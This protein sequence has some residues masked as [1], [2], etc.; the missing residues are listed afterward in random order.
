MWNHYSAAFGFVWCLYCS[1]MPGTLGGECS[2]A[3]W[4]YWAGR[5]ENGKRCRALKREMMP[6]GVICGSRLSLQMYKDQCFIEHNDVIFTDTTGQRKKNKDSKK[7][8]VSFLHHAAKLH[9]INMRPKLNMVPK[10][11]PTSI[12]WTN[13]SSLNTIF[14]ILHRSKAALHKYISNTIKE[15]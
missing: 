10:K 1:E 14:V 8:S 12:A 7:W 5:K 11:F 4:R 9:K 2:H 6:D 15:M 13:R 3:G